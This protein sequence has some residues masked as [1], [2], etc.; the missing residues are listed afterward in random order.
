[1]SITSTLDY[2]PQ[3]LPLTLTRTVEP[4]T[5]TIFEQDDGT[6]IAQYT[7]NLNKAPVKRVETVTGTVN[8][9]DYT[10]EEGTDYA[11]I[12]DSGDGEPDSID[13]SI[14]GADPDENTT[15]EVEYVAQSILNRYV[16]AYDTTVD[17]LNGDIQSAIESRQVEHADGR[18]ESDSGTNTDLDRIGALFGPLG[19][20]RGR[21]DTEYR[22]LLKSIVQS[23]SGRG[24]K[25]GMKFAIA[26]GIGTD[27]S[28]ITIDEDFQQVGY[29]I[30]VENVDTQFLSSV[31]NDMAQL[32]DP[33]G[34]ELLSPP[35]IVLDGESTVISESGSTVVASQRGMGGGTLTLDGTSALGQEASTAVA[36]SSTR[37]AT[38][39]TTTTAS[40]TPESAVGSPITATKF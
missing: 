24:T 22:A 36:S 12:D 28:N 5:F 1:M 14:G 3:V 37:S 31:V 33:S 7:Y 40:G 9:R 32:A 23:F 39:S 20:R 11:I 15:F 6:T 27:T 2:L 4:H 25:P 18:A 34:V 17:P 21:S 38:A 8:G 35:I 19:K 26:A 16:S 29:E 10:F 30:R 13:F